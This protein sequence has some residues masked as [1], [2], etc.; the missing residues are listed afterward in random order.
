MKRLLALL[1]A[2][3]VCTALPAESK[4]GI[5]RD[6]FSRL[7]IGVSPGVAIPLGEAGD[8]FK[9][10]GS[11]G[12]SAA[13]R[14]PAWPL[15]YGFAGFRYH[16]LPI[17]ADA[18]LSAFTADLGAGLSWYPLP[19][20]GLDLQAGGGYYIGRLSDSAGTPGGGFYWRGLAG[21][22]YLVS[23]EFGIG[24]GIGY[25]SFAGL[26]QGL[27]ASFEAKFHVPS[28]QEI[29]SNDPVFEAARGIRATLLFGTAANLALGDAA[30]QFQ[31]GHSFTAAARLRLPGIPIAFLDLETGL[32]FLPLQADTSVSIASLGG[33]A[34]V[35]LPLFP[36][37][38][39][40]AH[41]SCGYYFGLLMD[42]PS[43]N[44]GGLYYSG[45]ADVLYA[46][47]PAADLGLGI[48]YVDYTD[49]HAGLR[50]SL[51]SELHGLGRAKSRGSFE[52]VDV[53][54]SRLSLALVPALEVP[55]GGSAVNFELGS[56][57][58]AVGRYGLGF[59]PSLAVAAELGYSS[60]PLI[61][62]TQVALLSAGSGLAWGANLGPRLSLRA[63]AT[64]GYYYGL[65]PGEAASGGG[66][67]YLAS[68]VELALRVMDTMRIG[69]GLGYRNF[70]DVYQGLQVRLSTISYPGVGRQ[71]PVSAERGLPL[72]PE[73]LEPGT[74][75]I[76]PKPRLRGIQL[77]DIKLNTVFP[78]FYKY[79]EDH[80]VGGAI[81]GNYEPDSISDVK[82]TFHAPQYMVSPV[83]AKAPAKLES[84]EEAEVQFLGLFTD[85]VLEITE[86]TKVT[87]N[88]VF[89][90]T[91]RGRKQRQ[92]LVETLRL[93]DRNAMSWDDDRKA[94]AFVTAKDPTVLT[95]AKNVA[96]QLRSK[97][98]S[99]I[100]EN[101]RTAIGLHEALSLYGVNYVV[102]P[103]TPYAQYSQQESAVDFLQ[104]PSQTLSYKAG[105]CDDLSIL[106]CSLLESVGIE[107]AFITSPGHIYMAFLLAADEQTAKKSFSRPQDL[108]FREGKA[109]VPF[110]VTVREGGFLRAWAEGAKL[111][112]ES[113]AADKAGFFPV[114]EG[115]SAYEP[116][117]IPGEGK[118]IALPPAGRIEEAF[119]NELTRFVTREIGPQITQIEAELKQAQDKAKL[120]NR[121]GVLYGRYGLMDKARTAFEAAVTQ[122]EFA[123]ALVNLGNVLFLERRFP[124]ALAY[125]ERATRQDPANAAIALA[126]ARAHHELENYGLVQAS[127]AKVKELDPALAEQYSYLE[128]RGD[129]A[130][131]A[132]DAS[133]AK[134]VVLWQ[135]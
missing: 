100:D 27:V 71:R 111:W 67:F 25:E 12:L 29:R 63:D 23:P 8:Q 89:E 99:S 92:Q 102:D 135:D 22:S 41:G 120:H 97:G 31:A 14:L 76:Q 11:V 130:K 95:I 4:G 40:V 90:Y 79:Y 18:Q 85:D 64:G 16:N 48:S 78:V 33:G 74:E 122:R 68:G 125:Y 5:Y 115:W 124:E 132:A 106:Y 6:V 47:T 9:P 113:S 118:N 94:A 105:D 28:G 53:G 50:V 21:I 73:P 126:L 59:L 38:R 80:P 101:L 56:S 107:T 70:W 15:A 45:G 133:R 62:Q 110:E 30:G 66:S 57:L 93:Y 32:G 3:C 134:E 129:E 96:G 35:E 61:D 77:R 75:I 116:V 87:A 54:P 58:T 26:Y 72:R 43:D 108:I 39:L 119:L 123:P 20:L 83:A 98:G 127:Y 36:R 86:A 13:L 24:T 114:H 55:L 2:L 34:G 109:W 1:F 128:L 88:I 10:G 103:R 81:L 104:F 46:V 131:R 91:R 37:L 65:L 42:E 19:R 112:R 69:V 49:V 84:G 121:I 117:G 7:T 51:L 44:G 60:L 82:I 52:R 17:E